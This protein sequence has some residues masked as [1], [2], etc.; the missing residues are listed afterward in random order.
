MRVKLLDL[1]KDIYDLCLAAES[2][3][4]LVR[5]MVFEFGFVGAELGDKLF[6]S[7]FERPG[8]FAFGGLAGEALVGEFDVDVG[9][10]DGGGFWVAGDYNVGLN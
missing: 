7:F 6:E 10:K 8:K 9:G 4:L 3:G 1:K 5:V 2:A